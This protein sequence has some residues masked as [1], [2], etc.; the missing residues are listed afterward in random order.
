MP[1]PPLFPLPHTA[2]TNPSPANCRSANR[3]T[4]EPALRQ[5]L[6][7][8]AAVLD[9][10]A[11][12]Q[13]ALLRVWQVAPSF[14][15]DDKPNALLRFSLTVARNAAISELR[16]SRPR[17]E[18]LDQ[19]EQQLALDVEG[20]PSP[21]D[22]FLR[23]AIADCRSKLPPQP[24]LALEQRLASGGAED[25]ATLAAR[26]GMKRNTFLQNFTRARKLL[27]ECL[28]KNG[29]ALDGELR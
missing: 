27:R 24:A 16:R 14:T 22:P 6:R 20:R 15:P 19:L 2:T 29:V 18:Q 23:R 1:S 12:L 11:V 8:F 21:P 5:A 7:A 13:E 3:A 9:A 28:E 25:D 10:E 17:Q 4:A 26:L